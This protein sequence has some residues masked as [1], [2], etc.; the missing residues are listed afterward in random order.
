[1]VSALVVEFERAIRNGLQKHEHAPVRSFVMSKM[2]QIST[3]GSVLEERQ[4]SR[5]EPIG[6]TVRRTLLDSD[7]IVALS[8]CESIRLTLLNQ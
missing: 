5:T 4:E 8:D 1:M 6:E 3:S 2:F 7:G